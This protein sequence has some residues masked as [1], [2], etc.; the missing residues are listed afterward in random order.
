MLVFTREG[1]GVTNITLCSFIHETI[2]QPKARMKFV[3]Q[4]HFWKTI[5]HVYKNQSDLKRNAAQPVCPKTRRAGLQ[6]ITFLTF[7]LAQD[8]DNLNN[9]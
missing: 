6:S 8:K 4:V 7:S 5:L 2:R 3:F 1:N 9:V